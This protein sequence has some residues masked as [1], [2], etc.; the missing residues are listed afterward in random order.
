[1]VCLRSVKHP[2][3]I[4]TMIGP[5]MLSTGLWTSCTKGDG[6]FH[7]GYDPKR[8]KIVSHGWRNRWGEEGR[9]LLDDGVLLNVW[10]ITGNEKFRKVFFEIADKLL[11]TEEPAGNWMGYVP[12]NWNNRSIH[13]RQ[14]YWWGR[15]MWMAYKES[16]QRK[17]RECFDRACRWYANAMRRDGGVFRNTYADYK[18][19]S[20]GHATS[21]TGAACL[22]FRD[23]CEELNDKSHLPELIIGL[24]YM[25]SMQLTEA[26]DTNLRG[27]IL[28]KVSHPN[29]RR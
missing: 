4:D 23:Q 24:K 9:P 17:Y 11:K 18:T 3:T 12:C 22:M 7:D 10:K 8:K 1:M 21:G 29:R 2:A 28:E 20:F 14:A 27:A 16:G 19:A 6:H 15:P 25:L 13:P 5:W 26:G